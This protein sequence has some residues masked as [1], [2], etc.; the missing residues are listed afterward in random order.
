[1]TI[2]IKELKNHKTC[3]KCRKVKNKRDFYT[4]ERCKDGL[5]SWCIDCSN[6][7]KKSTANPTRYYNQN[8]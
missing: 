1:M 8:L 2:K 7:D 6:R 5:K 3:T 4:N